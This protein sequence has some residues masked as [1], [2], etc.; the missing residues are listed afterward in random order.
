MEES[1]K[2][3]D[4]IL[5]EASLKEDNIPNEI[6]T[7]FIHR[8]DDWRGEHV[9]KG[10]VY[11]T[12]DSLKSL[13]KEF[14]YIKFENKGNY[15]IGQD[16]TDDVIIAKGKVSATSMRGILQSAADNNSRGGMF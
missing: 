11:Q 10:E 1:K 14:S 5:K 9:G 3:V 13:K 12:K 4:K 8:E 7:V 15:L 6:H 2:I 16:E